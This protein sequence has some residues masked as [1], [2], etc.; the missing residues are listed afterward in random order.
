MLN[1]KE[2]PLILVALLGNLLSGAQLNKPIIDS[3]M[4]GTWPV[5]TGDIKI[6]SD[7]RYV[8]YHIRNQPL[9]SN[10]LVLQATKGNWKQE[11]PVRR[12]NINLIYFSADSRHLVWQNGDSLFLDPMGQNQKKLLALISGPCLTPGKTKGI[13]LAWHDKSKQENLVLYNLVTG[14][15]LTFPQVTDAVFDERGTVLLV[16]QESKR[17]SLYWV[18]L[19]KKITERIIWEDDQKKSAGSFLFDGPA[20]QLCFLVSSADS[21]SVFYYEQSMSRTIEKYNKALLPPGWQVTG[22]QGFNNTGQY[23][24]ADVVTQKEPRRIPD[25]SMVAVDVWSYRDAV[26]HP[27]QTAHYSAQYSYDRKALISIPS[28]EIQGKITLLNSK[29]LKIFIGY[30]YCVLSNDTIAP[31]L[32]FPEHWVLPISKMWLQPLKGGEPIELPFNSGY[33]GTSPRGRWLIFW[34]NKKGQRADY[35]SYEIATGKTCNITGTL[36]VSVAEEK[37]QRIDSIPVGIAGWYNDDETLLIYGNY[38]IWKLDPAGIKAPVNL[39]HGYGQLSNTKLRLVAG[40]LYGIESVILNGTE[41]LLLTGYNELT[42]YNGF[43]KL[44]LSESGKQKPLQLSMQPFSWFKTVSQVGV[45]A[46]GANQGVAPLYGGRNSEQLCVLMGESATEYPNYY[47]T[48]DFK[49]FFPL[50][51]LQPHKIFNW[52]TTEIVNWPLPGGQTIQGILY[53]PENFDS[54]QKYPLI[55]NYYER[56]SGW[57]YQFSNPGFSF[58]I[59]NIPWFVSRGYLVFT[60]DIPFSD[61]SKTGISSG[62]HAWLAVES[63]AEYLSRRIYIDSNRLGLQ[64]NSFGGQL[65]LC[66]YT[67]SKRFKAA[68]EGTGFTDEMSTYLDLV[69]IMGDGTLESTPVQATRESGHALYGATPWER[70]ELYLKNSSVWRADKIGGPLL[71]MHNKKDVQV[72]WKQGVA[73]YMALRRLGK[74]CWMLQYDGEGHGVSGKAAKDYTIRMTQYFDHYLNAKPAPRWMTLG[75]PARFKQVDNRYELDSIGM[76]NED[77]RVC[78]KKNAN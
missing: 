42:K 24:L 70:P 59:M 15:K 14:Q 52:L 21:P 76:C 37:I 74:P 33:T 35:Y 68:V 16:Y 25:P 12:G 8:A 60:P 41:E 17:H 28:G 30:D 18:T 65:T 57:M 53:K 1:I 46:V 77:C 39:T 69:N 51:R 9:G 5:L 26:I 56:M 78:N 32:N 10:T 3:T 50:T 4:V 44:R 38:D 36:P 11:R 61:G 43:F 72:P 23:L 31:P 22:L 6:S 66:I 63:A 45:S 58:G 62:E 64:G 47:Y 40:G 27:A 13:W 29:G 48:H 20:H 49:Q 55:F 71:I 7:G 75:I 34:V 73:M 67:R 54:T 2:Y 19:S